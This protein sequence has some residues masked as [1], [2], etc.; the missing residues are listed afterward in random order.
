MGFFYYD[1]TML[2]ILPAFVMAIWAQSRVKSTY[3]RYSQVRSSRGVAGAD[4]AREILQRNG[5]S[6]VGVEEVP[7]VLSDHYD[8]RSRTVRLSTDNFR[9]PSLAALAVAA[10]ECGHAIQ[11]A[12][13]YAPLR[14]RHTILPAANLGSG[15]MVWVLVM[16]GLFF[17]YPPLVDAGILFFAGAVVFHI[18]TL[19]VEFN[20]SSRALAILSNGGYLVGDENDGARKV[21]NAAA[22]TYVASA[23]MAVLQLARLLILR[24]SMRD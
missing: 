23:A 13:G 15:W 12:T 7:G 8:P 2:L 14:W 11:H 9:N 20:A 6:N 19:P 5:L 21:L 18:V 10:H 22:M 1:A 16:A 24:S 17:S 4:I 3:R